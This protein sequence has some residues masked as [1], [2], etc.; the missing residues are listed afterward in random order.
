MRITKS[1]Y[2][3]VVV[4]LD[5]MKCKEGQEHIWNGLQQKVSCLAIYTRDNQYFYKLD[6]LDYDQKNPDKFEF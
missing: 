2:E 6:I 5:I 1:Y 3:E 4:S